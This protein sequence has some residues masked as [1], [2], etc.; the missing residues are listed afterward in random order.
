MTARN[1]AGST[2]MDLNV[3]QVIR[4]STTAGS[5]AAA[6]DAAAAKESKSSLD[7]DFVFDILL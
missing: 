1:P 4:F 5:S 7:V 6:A 3:E 2:D